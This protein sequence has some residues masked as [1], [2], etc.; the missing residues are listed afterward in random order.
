MVGYLL[1]TNATEFEKHLADACDFHKNI[2][3]SASAIANAKL[4]IRPPSFLPWLIEEYGLG[5]LTLYVP[6]L[7][8][9]LDNGLQWQRVR[10]SLAAI[11]RGLEWLK[12]SARFQGAWAGHKWWNSFQL[13][14]DQLPEQRSLE[15]IEAII[16]LSKSLR[17]D[18][19][20]AVHGYSV[21][22]FANNMAK[23]DEAM[24]DA[25]SGTCMT[26]DG[27]LFSFGRTT[28][29]SHT[30]SQEE[31]EL[32]GNWIDEVSGELSWE[33]LDSLWEMA[34]FP[35][36]SVKEHERIILMA[37]WFKNHCLYLV[38]KDAEGVILGYR[39]CNI[40]QPVKQDLNGVYSHLS[41]R[42]SPSETGSMLFLAARTDFH[43][44]D[45]KK[46]AFVSLLI[47]ASLEKD[48]QPGKLWLQPDEIIGG[49]EI[50]QTPINIPLRADVREQFKILLRF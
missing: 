14:F 27:T 46:A 8:D 15:A 35:W 23:L 10:G 24:L 2:D 28:E 38:L 1:P 33:D 42:F 25:E 11:D 3:S 49:V 36:R 44:V 6:N 12:L 9:L 41:N 50:I 43:D 13:H 16:N 47:H 40:V 20:R 26:A 34:N 48:V 32:I 37:L 17:S 21:E 30:L 19:R 39:R 31:G 5:E 22:A 4:V 18:F 7:Y 45:R 29:I